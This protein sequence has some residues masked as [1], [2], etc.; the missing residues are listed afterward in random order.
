M[1]EEINLN[2]WA[3]QSSDAAGAF[4][5]MIVTDW[6]SSAQVL[7]GPPSGSL[8]SAQLSVGTAG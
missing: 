8:L 3:D 5:E 4:E 7:V 1:L 6:P 2:T